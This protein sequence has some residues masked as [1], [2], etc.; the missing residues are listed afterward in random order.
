M[1]ILSPPKTVVPCPAVSR[2]EKPAAEL[3]PSFAAS[4]PA[5]AIWLAE[6]AIIRY[7]SRRRR[8]RVSG[9]GGNCD[10]EAHPVSE[11]R[12]LLR[13]RG[14]RAGL[15][16]LA[17]AGGMAAAGVAGAAD[18]DERAAADVTILAE[19]EGDGRWVPADQT[20]Q[21][22]DTVTWSFAGTRTHNVIS[23]NTNDRDPRWE[24]FAYKG[25]FVPV[26]DD[27]STTFTF[28]KTGTYTYLCQ[29]HAGIGMQGTITVGGTD[30]EIP[31][32]PTPT[33]TATATATPTATPPGT[34][35][36]SP[37]GG[38]GGSTPDD[39]TVTPPPGGG[40]SDAVDPAISSVR[41]RG[42]RVRFRLSEAA[43]VTIQ[44]RKRGAKRVLRSMRV[45][46]AA[47]TRSVRL[48]GGKLRKGRYTVTLS[49]RDPF[50]NRSAAA[51]AA[52]R[53]R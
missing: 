24:G 6:V 16:A 12:E 48:R 2:F 20:I 4:Q 32:E 8:Q 42:T 3:I 47:G 23:T 39:H 9:A 13:G 44:V 50:G 18:S 41:A 35:L 40:A 19:G 34:Q 36:P 37:P 49:A 27:S 14:V 38:G 51:R 1:A 15:A 46:V 22:G 10:G 5:F 11:I 28:Y 43:T 45:Q 25:D 33:P 21:A 7:L 30:Q 17:V 31:S 26:T 52:L 53:V 29:F